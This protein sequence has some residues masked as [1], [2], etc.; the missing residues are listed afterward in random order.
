MSVMSCALTSSKILS[1][2]PLRRASRECACAYCT[3]AAASPLYL[4][5]SNITASSND[6]LHANGSSASRYVSRYRVNTL[7]RFM[8]RPPS[9]WSTNARSGRKSGPC[10]SMSALTRATATETTSVHSSKLARRPS[11]SFD[12]TAA[13]IRF[14]IAASS[15]S[16]AFDARDDTACFVSE[17][18]STASFI[19]PSTSSSGVTGSFVLLKSYPARSCTTPVALTL[20]RT[21]ALSSPSAPV[22]FRPGMTVNSPLNGWDTFT[23]LGSSTA[24][25]QSSSPVS[26][27]DPGCTLWATT[28]VL[29]AMSGMTVFMTSISQYATPSTAR[30]PSG[31]RYRSSFPVPG[32]HIFV[33]SKS[34]GKKHG[35]PS[36]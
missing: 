14:S 21:S 30:P 10:S 7:T 35:C 27:A 31:T 12:P 2:S 17:K 6:A 29:V 15:S 25:A 36:T 3:T 19:V 18:S 8:C 32:A 13:R 16:A 22:S 20:K 9:N 26:N 1:T 33:G 11:S 23:A 5:R 34:S 4:D 28:P 24:T